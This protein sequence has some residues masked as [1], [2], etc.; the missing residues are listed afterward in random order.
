[1]RIVT[2]SSLETLDDIEWY[3][4]FKVLIEQSSHEM[5]I[6][7]NYACQINLYFETI[8]KILSMYVIYCN[9]V[10]KYT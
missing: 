4:L 1:M 9:V 5:E 6:T 7:K 10:E 2:N 3:G 8:M